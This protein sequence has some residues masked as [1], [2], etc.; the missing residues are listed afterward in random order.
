MKNIEIIKNNQQTG[1]FLA[2][3]F[4]NEFSII[5]MS[6]FDTNTFDRDIKVLRNKFLDKAKN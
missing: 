3:L 6:Y 1:S 2:K 4:N 5:M